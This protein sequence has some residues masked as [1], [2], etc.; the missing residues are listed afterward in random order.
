MA[1]VW[2]RYL[3]HQV[4]AGIGP[5]QPLHSLHTEARCL[6]G[7]SARRGAGFG[8]Y[9][10]KPDVS[11]PGG[12]NSRRQRE[13]C[14]TGV[15]HEPDGPRPLEAGLLPQD[16]LPARSCGRCMAR[17][18]WKATGQSHKP[19]RS[20]HAAITALSRSRLVELQKWKEVSGGPGNKTWAARLR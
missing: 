11:P 14:L 1:L 6:R 20:Q 16:E 2:L 18:S 4:Y 5:R 17:S 9:E 19:P 8:I 15:G 7:G 12:E 3:P 10:P 13:E